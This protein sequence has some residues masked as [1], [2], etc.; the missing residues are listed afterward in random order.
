MKALKD[1]IVYRSKNVNPVVW[2]LYNEK[3]HVFQCNSKKMTRRWLHF[4]LQQYAAINKVRAKDLSGHSFR[5]GA[6]T[7]LHRN[8]APDSVIKML[9]RWNSNVFQIYLRHDYNNVKHF[10][11]KFLS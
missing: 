4:T 2:K 7:E 6:A 1:L 3:Q 9:G 11:N 10:R 5:I 8:G